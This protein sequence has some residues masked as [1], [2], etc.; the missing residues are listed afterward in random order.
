MNRPTKRQMSVVRPNLNPSDPDRGSDWM[1]V[2]VA[3]P[4][5]FSFILNWRLAPKDEQVPKL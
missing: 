5:A 1:G 3:S 4:H 2:D